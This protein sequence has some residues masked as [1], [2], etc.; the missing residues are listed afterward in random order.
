MFPVLNGR[1]AGISGIRDWLLRPKRSGFR[2]CLAFLAGLPLAPLVHTATGGA[3]PSIRGLAPLAGGH[4]TPTAGEY[5]MMNELM[6]GEMMWG[7][8]LPGI[9]I[10]ILLLLGVAALA[11][12]VFWRR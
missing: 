12:Y 7:M 8:G 5:A 3:V 11:K 1:V 9:L 10:V 6:G 2:S 4:S